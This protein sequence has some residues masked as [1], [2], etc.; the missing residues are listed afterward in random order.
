MELW[1]FH[2]VRDIA[3]LV[4][5]EGSSIDPVRPATKISCP[6]IDICAGLCIHVNMRAGGRSLLCVVHRG[7]HSNFFKGLW[8]RSGNNTAGSRAAGYAGAID[9]T[10]R[11]NLACALAV[12]EITCIHAVQ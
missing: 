5:E 12:E 9:D 8:R 10:C 3:V 11:W 1:H 7:I 6:V 2:V 4:E